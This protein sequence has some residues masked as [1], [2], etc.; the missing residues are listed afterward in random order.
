MVLLATTTASTSAASPAG[1]QQAR[2]PHGR[3]LTQHRSYEWT[4]SPS[5]VWLLLVPTPV[6]ADTVQACCRCHRPCCSA[7]P[8]TWSCTP[9]MLHMQPT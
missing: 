7:P 9:P 5:S 4:L 3:K 6:V 8:P 1:A 2:R